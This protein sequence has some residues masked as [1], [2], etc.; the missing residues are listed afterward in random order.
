ML[1][2]EL[3]E[4]R[5]KYNLTQVELSNMLGMNY[6]Y[7]QRTERGTTIPTK[8]NEAR[9]RAIMKELAKK[10]DAEQANN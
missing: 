3:L 6:N 9:I 2:D 7:V 5:A 4:F 8:K 1:K 10:Y